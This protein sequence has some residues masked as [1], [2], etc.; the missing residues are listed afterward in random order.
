[1]RTRILL[2]H[3]PLFAVGLITHRRNRHPLRA[4]AREIAR[5]LVE[6][7]KPGMASAGNDESAARSRRAV[8]AERETAFGSARES[9]GC[10]PRGRCPRAARPEFG[11]ELARA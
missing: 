10:H 5:R 7:R 2:R 8:G 3:D 1:M 6:A 4:L 11:R 9:G